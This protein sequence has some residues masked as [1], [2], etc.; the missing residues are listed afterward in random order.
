MKSYF[1]L[2]GLAVVGFA[3]ASVV[4]GDFEAS[5]TGFTTDLTY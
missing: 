2:A 3:N 5:N 4:N 1:L